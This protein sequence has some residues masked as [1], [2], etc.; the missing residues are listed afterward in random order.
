MNEMKAMIR[1]LRF[2]PDID[3]KPYYQDF[4]LE[5][6]SG[7]TILDCLINIKTTWMAVLRSGAHAAAVYAVH[8]RYASTTGQCWPARPRL[9]MW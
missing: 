7:T 6:S 2:N 5:L 8:A 4:E 1:I 9:W 3:E